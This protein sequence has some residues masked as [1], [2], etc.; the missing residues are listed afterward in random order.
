MTEEHQS[1]VDDTPI[2][3]L[4]LPQIYTRPSASILLQTLARLAIKPSS[5]TAGAEFDR[6]SEDDVAPID[7]HGIPQYLTSIISNELLWIEDEDDR[8]RVWEAASARLSER[9]G[10]TAQSN[11][12]R[13]F[14]IPR[15]LPST[16]PIHI[17]LLEPS[18]TGDNLGH[19]TWLSAYLLARRLPSLLPTLFPINPPLH[20]LEL[21]A[22]TG[23]LGLT[24][25]ALLPQAAVHL[26]DLPA[27]I[28][29]LVQNTHVNGHLF[30]SAPSVGVLDWSE[31]ASTNK[32]HDLILASDPLYSP[33]HPAWL[34]GTISRQL[35]TKRDAKVVM[36][37]PLRDAY[38]GEVHEMRHRM[39]G[40]GLRLL[41]SGE[42]V[43]R[44]DWGDSHGVERGEV[45]CW[46]GVWGWA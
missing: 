28:P 4:D 32:Q 38:L 5:W 31:S 22:G 14:L 10:R 21:G 46:W 39:L 37:L 34:V 43:G 27:I 23:L 26:T 35:S 17:T 30:A 13:T 11:L 16:S 24:V 45:R 20:I 33:Q 8:E 15:P 19:K 25:A 44:E 18:L 29:N 1:I 36:E 42:E 12:S 2:H 6:G 3:V 41:D 7:E 40:A 9:S